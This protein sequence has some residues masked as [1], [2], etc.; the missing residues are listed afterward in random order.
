[1]KYIFFYCHI[2][3]GAFFVCSLCMIS[4]QKYIDVSELPKIMTIGKF[5]L[6]HLWNEEAIEYIPHINGKKLDTTNSLDTY[7]DVI[8]FGIQNT[9]FNFEKRQFE[10]ED[11]LNLQ[12]SALEQGKRW[13]NEACSDDLVPA[14]ALGQ[15]IQNCLNG[16]PAVL[17]EYLN[18]NSNYLEWECFGQANDTIQLRPSS[19]R[20]DTFWSIYEIQETFLDTGGYRIVSENSSYFTPYGINHESTCEE[21]SSKS[22]LLCSIGQFVTMLGSVHNIKISKSFVA[23]MVN[24]KLL[25]RFLDVQAFDVPTP[26]VLGVIEPFSMIENNRPECSLIESELKTE[27]FVENNILSQVDIYMEYVW[28]PDY[29]C[30]SA[31][32]EE[33][34]QINNVSDIPCCLGKTLFPEMTA[35]NCTP[36]ITQQEST[37]EISGK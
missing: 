14:S 13:V 18:F 19:L 35:Y 27:F 16:F 31:T 6:N 7:G 28:Y 12:L 1:M 10:L 22:P 25:Y 2:F 24:R 23:P 4:K 29:Y 3:L 34:I 9:H 5:S 30:C 26:I 15:N 32:L 21:R 8:T 33:P 17:N 11:C 20:S 37:E 36:N